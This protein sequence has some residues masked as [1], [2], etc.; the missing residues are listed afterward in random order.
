MTGWMDEPD[1]VLVERLGNFEK[2]P[3]WTGPRDYR[4]S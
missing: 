4:I 3:R 2:T 1:G